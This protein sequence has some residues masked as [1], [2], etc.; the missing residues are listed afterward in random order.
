MPLLD[1]RITNIKISLKLVGENVSKRLHVF[2]EKSKLVS[3]KE[4]NFFVIRSRF[5]YIVFYTGLQD[6]K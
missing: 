3:K 5:V 1:Y 2:A 4:G 6:V